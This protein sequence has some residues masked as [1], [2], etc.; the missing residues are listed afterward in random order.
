MQRVSRSALVSYSSEQMFD[1]ANDAARYPEFLP[2]C[3]S[4][5]VYSET[6]TEVVASLELARGGLS[7]S[8]TTRNTVHRPDS[9]KIQLEEGP[10]SELSGEWSF[11]ALGNLGCKI[12]LNLKF[13]FS[14]G[15]LDSVL[16]SVFKQ[17]AD[18]LVDAFCDRADQLYSQEREVTSER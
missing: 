5:T 12:T 13:E 14:G 16:G 10:F 8:F 3:R 1:V 2:W 4:S 7:K 15:L 17:A 9:I 6:E 18:R 11:Q